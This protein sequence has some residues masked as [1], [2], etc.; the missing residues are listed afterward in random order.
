V[1]CPRCGEGDETGPVCNCGYEPVKRRAKAR[2]T[3]T[4]PID[5]T[6]LYLPYRTGQDYREAFCV[7][8]Y[9]ASQNAATARKR[10]T[11]SW[12]RKSVRRHRG[13]R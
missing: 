12:Y 13:K 9:A 5:G 11:C 6:K 7:C 1:K 8:E 4:C 2:I 3:T 10:K